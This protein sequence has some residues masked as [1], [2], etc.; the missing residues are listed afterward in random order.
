MGSD[1]LGV[2][3]K[4]VDQAF[5][6]VDKGYAVFRLT[7]HG[8]VTVKRD[9][10]SPAKCITLLAIKTAAVGYRNGKTVRECL[11]AE[12]ASD[13][14]RL[15]FDDTLSAAQKEHKKLNSEE[16]LHWSKSDWHDPKVRKER[17]K[18]MQGFQSTVNDDAY[19]QDKA[20]K[21]DASRKG[22]DVKR[23]PGLGRAPP[24]TAGSEAAEQSENNYLARNRQVT[25]GGQSFHQARPADKDGKRDQYAHQSRAAGGSGASSM[26]RGSSEGPAE[27]GYT[28]SVDRTKAERAKLGAD[29]SSVAGGKQRH[30]EHNERMRGE[31]AARAHHTSTVGGVNHAGFKTANIRTT[32]R[33]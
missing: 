2:K 12:Q 28:S 16:G 8:L 7:P 22:K 20:Q 32:G 21:R 5:W 6:L 14:T 3:M 29:D 4:A 10:K 25:K 30:A 27:R 18:Q 1:T 13:P 15:R 26:L 9:F 31:G 17:A 19:Y 11:D 23:G 33:G 24:D